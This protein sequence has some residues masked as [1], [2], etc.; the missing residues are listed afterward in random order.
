MF[1][2]ISHFVLNSN[3]EHPHLFVRVDSRSIVF[4]TADS[5]ISRKLSITNNQFV[6]NISRTSVIEP[7][8]GQLRIMIMHNHVKRAKRDFL[9]VV[10]TN[11]V[12]LVSS[13]RPSLF[14]VFQK[15]PTIE[16]GITIDVLDETISFSHFEHRLTDVHQYRHQLVENVNDK[17]T[18]KYIESLI[19][20]ILSIK[21]VE[22]HS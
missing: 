20:F 1:E 15:K 8:N 14:V 13:M 2:Q 21:H 16:F 17:Q 5:Y 12:E 3:T 4:I 10:L 18:L 19:D 9:K 22:K 6:F 11:T 7:G